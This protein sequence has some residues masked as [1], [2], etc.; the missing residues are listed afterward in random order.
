MQRWNVIVAALEGYDAAAEQVSQRLRCAWTS[1]HHLS[2]EPAP[3]QRL[4]ATSLFL[5][6]LSIT[7]EIARMA[8]E[9]SV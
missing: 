7:E 5:P 2:I 8:F 1:A 4:S 9:N 6:E 3:I